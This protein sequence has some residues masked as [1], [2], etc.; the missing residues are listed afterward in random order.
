[1][2][3]PTK[4]LVLLSLFCCL[5]SSSCEKD[6]LAIGDANLNFDRGIF[7]INEGQFLSANASVSFIDKE[8]DSVYNH[9]FYQ[10][11]QVP[12]GDVAHS[13]SI[14]QDDAYLVVNNSGKIYRT[15]RLNMNYHSKITG[16]VSPRSIIIAETNQMKAKAYISDLYSG[17]ILVADP[18]EGSLLD[19]IDISRGTDRFSTEQMIYFNNKLYVACWSYG[20]QIL[21]IDTSTDL[22]V[23]SIEVG[24]QPNSM[25]LDKQGYLWVLSDG[26]FPYSP[27]G[28]EKASLS[29]IN[30]E[31]YTVETMKIWDDIRLSPTDLCINNRGD[32]LYFIGEGVFKISL[33][34]EGFAEALI[35]ENGRHFYS[36]GVDPEDGKVYVGDAVDYQQDGWVYQ[37][38][39]GGA[40][41]D[42]FRVGVNP[43]YFCFTPERQL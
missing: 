8:R 14:W 6:P 43:G 27:F 37:F 38:S 11:N 21:V 17:K 23:D 42:S 35:P 41:M 20:Q 5:L 25:V 13:M 28:Q 18:I 40:V 3:D 19:S 7:V 9:I 31:T 33:A 10:A 30:L 39:P 1:M 15:D 24:K 2:I 34:M 32:S 12:L 16:L 4:L 29:R 36:L 22:L 26:G